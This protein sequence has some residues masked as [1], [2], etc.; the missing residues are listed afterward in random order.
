MGEAAIQKELLGLIEDKIIT[1][2]PELVLG[3]RVFQ[4]NPTKE[5]D[6]KPKE[7]KQRVTLMGQERADALKIYE[8]YPR[9][10][11]KEKCLLMIKAAIKKY[12]FEIVMHG[13]EKFRDAFL[14]SNT[15]LK[16]CEHDVK[17]FGNDHFTVEPE[18]FAF[19]DKPKQVM[20]GVPSFKQMID[21]AKDK[22]PDKA[23]CGRIVSG[24]MNYWTKQGWKKNGI[25]LDWQTE[26]ANFIGRERAKNQNQS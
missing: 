13:T 16:F 23:F 22:D 4:L 24:F 2:L 15:L 20:S 7:K 12:G 9:R 21:Y 1:E 5:V 3:N 11:N 19:S 14:A 18:M 17:F 8:V 10:I 6:V 25:I 26:L